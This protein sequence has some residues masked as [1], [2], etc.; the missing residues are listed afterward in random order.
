MPGRAPSKPLT[1]PRS[2]SPPPPFR[3]P[4]A[5]IGAGGPRPR[6]W[7]QCGAVQD[8]K[9]KAVT[10]TPSGC[11]SA[12]AGRLITAA[13][14]A[15]PRTPPVSLRGFLPPPLS[16]SRLRPP[17][18]LL[19]PRVSLSFFSVPFVC[20]SSLSP[21]RASLSPPFLS[22]FRAPVPPPLFLFVFLFLSLPR[23]R[24]LSPAGFGSEHHAASTFRFSGPDRAWSAELPAAWARRWRG[25]LRPPAPMW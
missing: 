21:P 8:A 1:A 18:P 9:G 22:F 4:P 3:S 24:P 19:F 23:L 15:F 7:R 5:L 13:H 11:I 2:R 16:P 14:P 25:I 12:A 6:C 17:P 10:T 20:P